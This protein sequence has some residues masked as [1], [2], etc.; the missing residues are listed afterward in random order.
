MADFCKACSI[1]LFGTDTGDLKGLGRERKLDPEFG[2]PAICEGCGFI[3]VDDEGNCIDCDLKKGQ[4]G[5][6]TLAA[7]E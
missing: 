6:G 7:K 5:H 2:W 3:L 1:E 4:P